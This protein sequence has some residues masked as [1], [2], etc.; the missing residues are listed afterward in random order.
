VAGATA[1]FPFLADQDGTLR[2]GIQ[3]RPDDPADMRG[4]RIRIA[5]TGFFEAMGTKLLAGRLF[6]TAD[7]L[8]GEPVIVVNHAFVR[9][10]FP[11]GDS[12]NHRVAVGYPQVDPKS[13]SR[14]VGVVDDVRYR[15]LEQDA[16]PAIYRPLGQL[17]FPPLR[18]TVAIAS[19]DHDPDALVVPI[20]D[21]MKQFDPRAIVRFDRATSIVSA[22]LQR[23]ALGMTLMLIFGA[24]ALVLGAI[25][26]YGVI[27]YAATQRRAEIATRMA[28][29]ASRWD[30]FW[31]MFGSG[32]RLGAV[33]LA[34]GVAIA[35]VGGR[36][37]AGSVS[38]V[39]ASD[40]LVLAGAFVAVAAV[41]LLAIA[42]P[43][44]RACRL[45]PA[46]AL[47]SE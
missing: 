29:G 13:A 23:Q 45:D 21:A 20:R 6:T 41:T 4:A 46:L 37:V 34:I 38:G 8:D 40:P 26:I 10:F 9:T 25:G 47:R 14:I 17:Q 31:L 22:T 36:I 15:S 3:G 12:L 39:S 42:I 27:A 30:V 11:D 18:Q 1:T 2:V 33:G 35:Y 44:V 32:E 24:T 43:A 19:R 5:G 16:E 28:L 7:R